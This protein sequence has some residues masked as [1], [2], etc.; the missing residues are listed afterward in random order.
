VLES[1][2]RI[3]TVAQGFDPTIGFLHTIRRGWVALVYDL[4][5]PLRPR[6]DRLVLGFL[7]S[8]TFTPSDFILETSGACRLHPQLARR[9]AGA[10]AEDEAIQDV[11][12]QVVRTLR[13]AA[14]ALH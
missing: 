2:V 8:H 1:Q 6:V 4:M 13:M 11:T 7:R 12:S 5:E 3:A 10:S 14:Q 9:V